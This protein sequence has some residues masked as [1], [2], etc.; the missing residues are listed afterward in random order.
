MNANEVLKTIEKITES[1][2]FSSGSDLWVI[3]NNSNLNWWNEL[4][5]RSGY[6]FSKTVLFQKSSESV[7]LREVIQNTGIPKVN[8]PTETKS[9]LLGT[10]DHFFN[11]WVYLIDEYAAENI[12]EILKVCQKLHCNSMRF[13]SVSSEALQLLPRLSASITSITYLE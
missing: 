7:K 10:E 9:I 11:K 13:F 6:L 5:F 8:H 3:P 12:Q 1:E 2:A 4:D